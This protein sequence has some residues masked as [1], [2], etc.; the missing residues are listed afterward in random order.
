MDK[1]ERR[2]LPRLKALQLAAFTCLDAQGQAVSQGMGKTLNLTEAGILLETH[3]QLDMDQQVTLSIGLPED[4]VEIPGRVVHS[5]VAA[6]GTH[7]AGIAFD[8]ME[9][10]A[11]QALRM[12]INRL[13]GETST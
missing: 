13:R 11:R 2:R 6:D 8:E 3:V 12:F 1:D 4:M 10:E 5:R 7:R 9:P